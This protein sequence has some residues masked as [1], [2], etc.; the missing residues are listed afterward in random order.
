MSIADRANSS[1]RARRLGE[2]PRLVDK[3]STANSLALTGRSHS[4]THTSLIWE[5]QKL[6]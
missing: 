4:A 3:T 1:A 6:M 2:G 5:V